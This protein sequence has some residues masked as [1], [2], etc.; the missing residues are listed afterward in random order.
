MHIVFFDSSGVLVNWPVPKGTT[1]NAAYYKWVLQEKLRPAIRKK[2]PGLKDGGII[3]HHDNAP[4]H[5]ARLLVPLDVT[6]IRATPPIWLRLT[7]V[8]SPR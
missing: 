6:D 8:Y 4:V 1:V 2:R 3:F 7:S 5:T